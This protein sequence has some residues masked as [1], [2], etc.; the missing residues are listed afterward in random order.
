MSLS[1]AF[2]SL[3]VTDRA[4]FVQKIVTRAAPVAPADGSSK[5]NL[6]Y[7]DEIHDT[8]VADV[9]DVITLTDHKNGDKILL[10]GLVKVQRQGDSA[11]AT[12]WYAEIL[13][14][15]PLI[16][17]DGTPT[18]EFEAV[19]LLTDHQNRIN[20][21]RLVPKGKPVDMHDEEYDPNLTSPSGVF[22]GSGHEMAGSGIFSPRKQRMAAAWESSIRQ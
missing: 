5:T 22:N 17:L 3:S 18:T 1:A 9:G 10:G 11:K 16:N 8:A 14:V 6:S 19:A 20:V 12:S 4:G 15:A 2:Y 13:L 21:A 7:E